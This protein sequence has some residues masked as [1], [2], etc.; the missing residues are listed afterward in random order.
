LPPSKMPVG[1]HVVLIFV[2]LVCL[3]QAIVAVA[4][5]NMVN[6]QG[7]GAGW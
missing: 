5:L 2:S 7:I 1:Y 3:A 6:S 4:L